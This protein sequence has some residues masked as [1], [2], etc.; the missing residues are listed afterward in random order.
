MST[1]SKDPTKT[2]T[3][4]TKTKTTTTKKYTKPV[5][6]GAKKVKRKV[7]KEERKVELPPKYYYFD[8]EEY[9]DDYEEDSKRRGII[10]PGEKNKKSEYGYYQKG[11]EAKK[12][13]EERYSIKNP[14][15]ERREASRGGRFQTEPNQM[16][17]EVPSKTEENLHFYQPVKRRKVPLKEESKE[18]EAEEDSL[19]EEEILRSKANDSIKDKERKKKEMANK[20]KGYYSMP[21]DK[22]DTQK[23]SQEEKR[24]KEPIKIYEPKT[25]EEKKNMTEEEKL[26]T[27]QELEDRLKLKIIRQMFINQTYK[28]EHSL[29]KFFDK[30]KDIADKEAKREFHIKNMVRRNLDQKLN[31][32][33][34]KFTDFYYNGVRRYMTMSQKDRDRFNGIKK[35]REIVLKKDK[36]IQEIKRKYFHKFYFGGVYRQIQMQLRG[37]EPVTIKTEPELTPEELEAKKRRKIK[38]IWKQM[39]QNREDFLRDKFSKFFYRGI[40]CEMHRPKPTELELPPEEPK[41]PSRAQEMRK[42]AR[43]AIKDEEGGEGEKKAEGEKK[44]EMPDR[45]KKARKLRGVLKKKAQI[46]IEGLRKAFYRFQNNG[47]LSLLKKVSKNVSP[48][49]KQPRQETPETE[50]LNKLTDQFI[51]KAE[52]RQKDYEDQVEEEEKRERVKNLLENIIYKKR[53]M[54]LMI[55]KNRFGHYNLANKIMKIEEMQPKTVIKKKKKKKKKKAEDKVSLT[56]PSMESLGSESVEDRGENISLRSK[57][58]PRRAETEYIET[59]EMEEIDVEAELNKRMKLKEL[60]KNAIRK[61]V[62]PFFKRWKKNTIGDEE[63]FLR[64]SLNSQ[65]AELA[66]LRAFKE[67]MMRQNPELVKSMGFSEKEEE[68]S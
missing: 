56:E 8:S 43:E 44:E 57:N 22:K 51:E 6:V 23:Q 55:M 65:E 25:E 3:S 47:I 9:S 15:K 54:E 61:K 64:E 30:W 4:T 27:I 59:E 13:E 41:K 12:G 18:P 32:V 24:P 46:D 31:F 42:K 50:D 2:K 11:K 29:G 28:K 66:Q 67:L 21:G 62:E 49:K 48:S 38:N 20:Y 36:D 19:D 16:R 10:I 17:K 60:F 5:V 68:D 52:Q 33:R 45:R 14:F 37:E 53:R 39:M 34:K 58:R 1:R 7:I 63:Q 40:Y 26:K 35:L